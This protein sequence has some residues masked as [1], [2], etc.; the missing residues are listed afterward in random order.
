M[1]LIDQSLEHFLSFCSQNQSIKKNY[2]VIRRS[3]QKF[4]LRNNTRTSGRKRE[5][6]PNGSNQTNLPLLIPFVRDTYPFATSGGFVS[7]KIKAATNAA[8]SAIMELVVS[9]AG[10]AKSLADVV[11]LGVVASAS[12]PV[13]MTD[14]ASATVVHPAEAPVPCVTIRMKFKDKQIRAKKEFFVLPTN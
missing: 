11:A 6:T 8:A 14:I 4:M 2:K 10:T 5:P 13:P 7:S 1:Y 3:S 12:A 9:T